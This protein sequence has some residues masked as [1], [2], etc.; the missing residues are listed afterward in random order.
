[1][2]RL[3]FSLHFHSEGCAANLEAGGDDACSQLAAW[4]VIW[5]QS[6]Q[7]EAVNGLDCR[8]RFTCYAGD[9][10]EEAVER[11]WRTWES[12]LCKPGGSGGSFHELSFVA[13]GHKTE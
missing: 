6:D 4:E 1:M 7:Q 5:I 11:A 12:P 8:Y 9:D 13:G 3:F 2:V 10:A